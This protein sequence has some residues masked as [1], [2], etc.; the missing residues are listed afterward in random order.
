MNRQKLIFIMIVLGSFSI[1]AQPELGIPSEPGKCYAKCLVQAQEDYQHETFFRYTG[2]AS[3]T[4]QG[5]EEYIVE[6]TEE[7]TKW[8]KKLADKNCLSKYP[9]DCMVWCLV[10]EPA[11][12]LMIIEVVDTSLC[13]D[14]VI[15]SF[16]YEIIIREGGFTAWRE[17]VCERDLTERFIKDIQGR[18]IEADALVQGESK[19]GKADGA[20]KAAL[21]KFQRMYGLPLGQLDI[22]TLSFLGIEWNE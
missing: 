13:K 10:T 3:G 9:E 20:F 21:T 1:Q 4:V 5:V 7:K 15:D 8:V 17:V 18:L 2:N 12:E 22:E 6:T 14:F 16:R 11:K 19:P